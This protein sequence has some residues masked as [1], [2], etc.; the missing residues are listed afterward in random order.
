[1]IDFKCPQCGEQMSVPSCLMGETDT[2][3]SCHNEVDV[4]ITWT[5]ADAK[6]LT[7]ATH[8]YA[9]A[10]LIRKGQFTDEE[11]ERRRKASVHLL[12]KREWA[13]VHG[14]CEPGSLPVEKK[15]D[16][17]ICDIRRE[18]QK[19]QFEAFVEDCDEVDPVFTWVAVN[20][21][22]A[23]EDCQLLH[24]ESLKVSQWRKE[25]MPGERGTVCGRACECQL[26]PR[27]FHD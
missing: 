12:A 18:A 1:M 5:K 27:S 25:G 15:H 26:V 7:D 22:D 23:C 14:I 11:R 17:K 3:P 8:A 16:E 2:C 4:P 19:A 24:G 13:K 21:S 20:G 10:A 6:L 9:E